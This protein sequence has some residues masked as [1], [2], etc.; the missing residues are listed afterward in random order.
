M[1][2]N[3]QKRDP[4]LVSILTSLKRSINTSFLAEGSMKL[5]TILKDNTM[6]VVLLTY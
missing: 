6:N 4:H 2:G 1:S 5:V 3:R